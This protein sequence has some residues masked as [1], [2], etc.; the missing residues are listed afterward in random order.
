MRSLQEEEEPTDGRD[1]G[2]RRARSDVHICVADVS[3]VRPLTLFILSALHPSVRESPAASPCVRSCRRG[4]RLK[5]KTLSGN[6]RD[7][8]CQT[9][10]LTDAGTKAS[11]PQPPSLAARA[12]TRPQKKK[13]KMFTFVI[14]RRRAINGSSLNSETLEKRR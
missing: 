7:T 5:I 2:R 10:S 8:V 4:P 9:G 13:K 14:R 11:S 3:A 6:C 12:A 1:A